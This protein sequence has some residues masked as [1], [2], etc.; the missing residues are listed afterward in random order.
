[1]PTERIARSYRPFLVLFLFCLPLEATKESPNDVFQTRRVYKPGNITLGGLFPI[2]VRGCE[3]NNFR[4]KLMALAEAMVFSI[5]QINKDPAL[6][7]NFTLGYEIHDTCLVTRKT[8]QSALK[9]VNQNKFAHSNR[10]N[11]CDALANGEPISSMSAVIGTGNSG[12][13]ILVS[14]L[15]NVEDIPLISYAATSD[16]LSSSAYPTFLRTVPPDRFQSRAM[17]EIARH[18]NWTYV[19]AI[20]VDDA[21]GQS[22]IEEFSKHSGTL[23]I[24]L[25]YE[26]YFPPGNEEENRKKKIELII[27]DLKKRSEVRVIVLYSTED[28]AVA[29]ITEAVRQE[30]LGRTWIASEAWGTSLKVR[31]QDL[32]PVVN[33]MLGV[34][35]RDIQVARYKE[36]LLSKT[37]AYRPAPWWTLFWE[38]E[39]KCEFG[40]SKNPCPDNLKITEDIYANKLHDSK[41]A[42]VIDAVYAVAHALDSITRCKERRS[43]NC[44]ETSPFVDAKSVLAYLRK[45]NFTEFKTQVAFDENG[46]PASS[47][48][49]VINLQLDNGTANV[50]PVGTWIQH[51][52]PALRLDTSLIRWNDG[53]SEGVTRSVCEEVCRP[54]YWQTQE[55]SCCW[56]CIRCIEDTISTIQGAPNCTKCSENFISNSERTECFAV[57]V[58]R[59][60]YGHPLGILFLCLSILGVAVTAWTVYVFYQHNNTPMVKASNR[61]LS[62]MLLFSI[63]M[64]YF[65]PVLYLADPSPM[66]CPL[67]QA[68]FY[69]FYTACVAILGAKTNRIV[70]LFESHVPRSALTRPGWA[71]KHRHVLLVLCVVLVDLLVI[72]FW[73][74]FD[75]PKPH[76]DKSIR[77]EYFK[78]CRLSSSVAGDVCQYLLMGLLILISICCSYFAYRARKLPHNF[79]EAK[80]IAFSLYVLV[81]SW[82]TFYPVYLNIEGL[83]SVVV[84]CTTTFIASTGLL[85]CIFVPKIYIILC[86]P[87]KNT[88]N[89]MKAQI[90]NH[91]FRKSV[92]GTRDS[93]P[94]NSIPG[95]D[96]ASPDPE[97][98]TRM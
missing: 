54:G 7:P 33:G 58:R 49:N 77:T 72:V 63:A 73:V 21:Y 79:N 55:R 53:K 32:L 43:R 10:A 97:H 95:S 65:T 38:R 93:M 68:W 13:S 46:D 48:Y 2:H 60:N 84:S 44:P 28:D 92:A 51:R 62:Y 1:M 23:G 57:P 27:S 16:E 8:M 67:H 45:V 50:V 34:V 94:R 47:S 81:L 39:F 30:L 20:A 75:P 24:C 98:T 71:G 35:F 78:R 87:E 85:V 86:H 4:S 12:S 11:S 80:F 40:S 42:S 70:H 31:T 90:T 22:G 64:C 96:N 88:V 56:E 25:A 41:S 15:L 66:V 17:A 18:F 74:I 83:Y 5:E 52:S 37:S 29:V 59:I 89:F 26:N 69:L 14:N 19:A 91:T 82:V 3:D 61:E 9:F 76:L 6:L 36:H